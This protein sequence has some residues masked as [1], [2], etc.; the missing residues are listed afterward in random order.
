MRLE[1]TSRV[2]FSPRGSMIALG[3]KA[4]ILD[5]GY[6]SE[7]TFEI[8][9]TETEETLFSKKFPTKFNTIEW[10]DYKN[11][12][13]LA[14]GLEGGTI[15]L[16]EASPMLEGKDPQEVAITGYKTSD[17]I[18]SLDFSP[19]M[20]MLGTGSSGGKIMVW[21]FVAMDKPFSPGSSLKFKGIN[22]LQ[23]NKAI[24]QVMAVGTLDGIVSVVD[25][26]GKNQVKRFEEA[27]FSKAE[28]T[29]LQ[30]N[31]E[32]QMTIA[33]TSSSSNCKDVFIYDLR[34]TKTPLVLKGGHS[35][36]ILKCA[37]SP[38]DPTLMITCGC[39]GKVLAWDAKNLKL[40]GEILHKDLFDFT[41]SPEHPDMVAYSSY[42][43]EVVVD[44]LTSLNAKSQFLESVPKWCKKSLG[45]CIVPGGM[46]VYRK[47]VELRRWAERADR[48]ADEWKILAAHSKGELREEIMKMVKIEKMKPISELKREEGEAEAKDEVKVDESEEITNSLISG[49]FSAAFSASLKEDAKLAALVAL[50]EGSEV[51]KREKGRILRAPGASSSLILLLS[52]LS[53]DYEEL[54]KNK[55]DWT[56]LVKMVARQSTDREFVEKVHSLGEK[57]EKTNVVSAKLCYLISMD[58]QKY[59]EIS[60]NQ[61]ELPTSVHEAADFYRKFETAFDVVEEAARVFKKTVNVGE[62]SMAY[63]KHLVE[64]GESERVAKFSHLLGPESQKKV[65]ETLLVKEAAGGAEGVDR[66]AERLGRTHIGNKE[67]EGAS[68]FAK[69]SAKPAAPFSAQMPMTPGIGASIGASSQMP[70]SQRVSGT[71]STRNV[72]LGSAT[73]SHPFAGGISSQKSELGAGGAQAGLG[74]SGNAPRIVYAKTQAP[75]TPLSSVQSARSDRGGQTPVGNAPS[76]FEAGRQM[77]GALGP[78]QGQP[79]RPGYAIAKP[80]VGAPIRQGMPE[81]PQRTI[82]PPMKPMH[83]IGAKAPGLSSP[84]IT[85]NSQTQ[86][87]TPQSVSMPMKMAPSA[88]RAYPEQPLGAAGAGGYYPKPAEVEVTPEMERAYA[89]IGGMV[90]ALVESVY[91]KKGSLKTWMFKAINPKIDV[92]KKQLE[93]KKWSPEFLKKM[94]AFSAKVRAILVDGAV[95][96]SA[97]ALEEIRKAGEQITATRPQGTEIEVWMGAIYSLLK[98]GSH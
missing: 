37:W 73:P 55:I 60:E 30:W 38:H 65:K 49:D 94:D 41:F 36:G 47:K 72:P 6:T 48:S 80:G 26:R 44:T 3:T 7:S 23:W 22:A 18:L 96:G 67:A 71:P 8:I 46:V 31:P 89:E 82:P 92:L 84:S 32:N 78:A 79:A 14:G 28:I 61:I 16:W 59:Q 93:Q 1:R 39:D 75:S 5:L 20:P 66:T 24:P 77:P 90:D 91:N 51:L 74:R 19:G 10:G 52:I 70:E 81:V 17:D 86:M 53:G 12:L 76:P 69:Y 21:N 27:Y 40:R 97:E 56:I 33:V 62:K 50:C 57:F 64:R 58:V 95:L 35:D 45:M 2:S 13:Y 54:V 63:L 98:V 88:G 25:L 83:P 9:S 68:G 4:K 87:Q 15:S 11:E 43:G 42:D 85:L 29:S 34:M